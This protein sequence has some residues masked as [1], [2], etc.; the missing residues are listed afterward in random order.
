LALTFS[1]ASACG[2]RTLEYDG[3]NSGGEGN[4]G[5]VGG[6]G[7]GGAKPGSG[8]Q[9]GANSGFGGTVT[10]GVTGGGVSGSQVVT[11][12]GPT[13]GGTGGG[14]TTGGVAGSVAGSAPAA[15]GVTMTGG[16]G[17]S[18][19]TPGRG[20]GG[21]AGS[22]GRGVG[23]SAGAPGQGGTGTMGGAG[24]QAGGAAG[25]AGGGGSPAVYDACKRACSNIPA[26]CTSSAGTADECFDSCPDLSTNV[27]GC[28]LELADYVSCVADALSPSAACMLTGAGECVGQGCT[29]TAINSCSR[30][31]DVY[32]NCTAGCTS[33][34][35]VGPD[36][37]S[38]ARYCPTHEYASRCTP[39][40]SGGWLCICSID[41]QDAA[42]SLLYTD[43]SRACLDAETY[44]YYA[45]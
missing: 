11:G 24:G 39:D 44:C 21:R 1:V 25:Q 15:G 7:V 33:G 2:G 29:T 10:A 28:P 4:E 22:P 9:G 6:S 36:G 18:G 8:G 45:R 5:G 17:G 43:V 38:Y 27:A 14:N 35:S 3:A 40:A 23:G 37:C 41:G 20:S 34:Y 32:S 13:S 26:A 16:R 19:A 42:K 12:G 31:L 30:M